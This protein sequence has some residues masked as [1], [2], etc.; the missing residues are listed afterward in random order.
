MSNNESERHRPLILIIDD[1]QAFRE[2]A[3]ALLELYGYAVMTVESGGAALRTIEQELPAIILLDVFMPGMDGL[4][5]LRMLREAAVHVPVLV[6][7]GALAGDEPHP[8]LSTAMEIGADGVLRKPVRIEE[9]QS[10]IARVAPGIAA[11][12]TPRK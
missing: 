9:L 5:F 4:E 12:A 8:M 2:T 3:E 10:L 1:D 6:T 7:T 11:A